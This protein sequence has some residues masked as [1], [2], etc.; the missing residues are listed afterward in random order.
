MPTLIE[1]PKCYPVVMSGGIG[2]IGSKL[3]IEYA[4]SGIQTFPISTNETRR[5]GGTPDDRFQSKVIKPLKKLGSYEGVRVAI[6]IPIFVDLRQKRAVDVV[7]ST[8]ADNLHPDQKVH[9][10]SLMAA[11]FR[12]IGMKM[13]RVIGGLEKRIQK[14]EKLC[15]DDL[16][17]ATEDI[18]ELTTSEVSLQESLETNHIAALG[19]YYGFNEAGWLGK[20]S[21][22]T[23]LSSIPTDDFI[24]GRKI[25]AFYF[26]PANGKSKG[27]GGQEDLCRSNGQR[28]LNLVAPVVAGTEVAR[29]AIKIRNIVIHVMGEDNV[30][31]IQTVTIEQ[32]V[33]A[34]AIESRR[35]LED[36]GDDPIRKVY[37]GLDGLVYLTRPAE[38]RAPILPYF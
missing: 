35:I 12:S 25:N 23:N 38:L 32:V 29:L 15:E 22:T 20:N 3:T 11:G 6:P 36:E 2:A 26:G 8:L 18:R 33:K 27:Q 17:E 21:R 16:I 13:A 9:Y 28:Y 31:E 34:L 14:H 30:P 24:N 4:R 1:A 5:F 19:L 37:L 10:D 7:L